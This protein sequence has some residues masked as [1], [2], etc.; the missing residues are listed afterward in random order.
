MKVVSVCL[1][2][3]LAPPAPLP[4]ITLQKCQNPRQFYAPD[5]T[6]SGQVVSSPLK[7]RPECASKL[8]QKGRVTTINS[9]LTAPDKV[10]WGGN[11][12]LRARRAQKGQNPMGERC[13][14]ALELFP[15][16]SIIWIEFCETVLS[17]PSCSIMIITLPFT[18]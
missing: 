17:T 10:G 16:V 15:T 11:G 14:N 18:P 8:G 13:P 1:T 9:S 12:S 2:T 6:H 4:R 3:P 5:A 7:T